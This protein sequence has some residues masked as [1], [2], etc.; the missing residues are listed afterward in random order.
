MSSRASSGAIAP[1]IDLA[2]SAA[3]T[4]YDFSYAA[5]DL[6][7]SLEIKRGSVKIFGGARLG[8]AATSSTLGA[9]V[10]PIPTASRSTASQSAATGIGGI[11][12]SAVTANGEIASV[13]YRGEAG[14][15]AGAAQTDHALNG[16]VANSRIMVA[17][18]LGRRDRLGA[19]T[20]HG[21]G[22][23]GVAMTRTVMLQVSAGNY[24]SNAMLGTAAGKFVTAGLAMRLGR[25]PGTMPAPSNIPAPAPG[26]TRVSIRASDASRVELAGDF[27]K[28]QPIAATRADNGVWYVDLALPPG[29]YRYAFR[30]NGKEWRVPEGV[31]AVDD[32]FGGK[33]AW[34]KVSKPA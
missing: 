25:T 23:L 5:A 7:P 32:E 3:T 6:T 19:A 13:G 27:N 1:V 12:V 26:R 2:L 30:V 34:L 14:R 31:A 15:V 18:S 8:V 21:S 16:A 20:L 22:T 9:L 11:S 33:S 17:A 29:K 4:S 24:P 10:G 28:W